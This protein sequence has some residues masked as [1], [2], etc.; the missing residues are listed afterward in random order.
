MSADFRRAHVSRPDGQRLVKSSFGEP[1][2]IHATAADTGGAF[3]IWEASVAPGAGPL[4]HA[5]TRET[6]VFRVLEGTFRFW[7]G[8]ETFEGGPGTTVTLPP[9]VPHY[10]R[11]IGDQPGRMIGIVTPGGFE[12]FFIEIDRTGARMPAELAVIEARLGI[13]NE[14]TEALA[15]T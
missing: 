1:L 11:N 10:W 7:C 15:A 13:I 2:V 9:H 14:A 5:H 3:G 12:Q 4:P 8:D 6:E